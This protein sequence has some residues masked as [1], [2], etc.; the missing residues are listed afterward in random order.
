MILT[1]FIYAIRVKCFNIFGVEGEIRTHGFRDLQSLALDHSATSTLTG[2][3]PETR[4]PTKGFGDP[5]AA[6]TPARQY[7]NY[8]KNFIDCQLDIEIFQ[9]KPGHLCFRIKVQVYLILVVI[10]VL[11]IITQ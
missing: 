6:I 2:I 3:P 7:S 5:R 4:T 1:A 9:L 11:P 8:T 10:S